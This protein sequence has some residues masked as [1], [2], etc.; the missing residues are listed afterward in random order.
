MLKLFKERNGSSCKKTIKNEF[1]TKVSKYI[2]NIGY[3]NLELSNK[4]EIGFCLFS[5]EIAINKNIVGIFRK[6]TIIGGWEAYNYM[7]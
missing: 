1:S 5:I 3:I 7:V 6:Q 4:K 2:P